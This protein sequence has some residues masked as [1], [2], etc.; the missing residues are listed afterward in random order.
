MKTI[1]LAGGSGSGK[2][3]VSQYLR[4]RGIPCFDCDEVYH[5]L[6]AGDSALSRELSA[7]FGAGILQK[8]GG[9]DRRSLA[10]IVYA[11]ERKLKLLDQITHRRILKSCADWIRYR[12]KKGCRTVLIDAPLLFESGLDKKCDLTVAVIAPEE[13]R[14]KR[15]VERDRI[16]PEEARRRLALQ[17]SDDEL[18]RRADRLIS[19]DGDL[20]ELK[21]KVNLFIKSIDEG[22]AEP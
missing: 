9:I 18:R 12:K 6:I 10:A 17:I 21:E 11:D 22:S 19:N 14:L 3:A 16:S 4:S 15:I 5:K 1:G 7:A 2:G 8:N 20:L 13:I